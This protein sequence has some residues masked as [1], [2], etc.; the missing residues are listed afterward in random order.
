VRALATIA[1]LGA[2]AA[3]AAAHDFFIQPV[4]HAI[5]PRTALEVR[6]RVGYA[7]EITEFARST[8]HLK[9]FEAHDASGLSYVTGEAGA[10][11][12][13][14]VG[15]FAEGT[16]TLVYQSNHSYIELEAAAFEAYL[17]EEGL[18]IAERATRGETTMVGRESYAR[19]TKSLVLVGAGAAGFD[20]VIGLPAVVQ[21]SPSW[22]SPVA[23]SRDASASASR[24]T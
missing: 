15:L 4:V 23:W 3:P 2:L 22:Q 24:C 6:L 9:R 12:A 17:A 7:M 18:I 21:G 5:A 19:Y 20:R 13:G 8:A 14:H 16:T 1:A 11:P 10:M